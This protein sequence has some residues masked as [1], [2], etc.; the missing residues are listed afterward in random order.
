[1]IELVLA[2]AA[3]SAPASQPPP[4]VDCC[5]TPLP[6]PQP[7]PLNPV[8]GGTTGGVTTGPGAEATIS[9]PSRIR[10]G[11]VVHFVAEPVEEVQ[12]CYSV[13]TSYVGCASSGTDRFHLLVRRGRVQYLTAQVGG[14]VYARLT[15]VNGKLLAQ[16]L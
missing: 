8:T 12:L 10:T 4:V 14:V 9:G 16:K 1:M 11:E 6:I 7:V 2:A 13:G 5:P 15:Y 3:L